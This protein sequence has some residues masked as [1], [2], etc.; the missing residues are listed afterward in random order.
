[1]KIFVGYGYNPRDAWIE[2]LVFQLIKAFGNE[3]THGKQ[4]YGGTLTGG[5]GDELLESNAMIG[6]RTRRGDPDSTGSY[7]THPWVDDELLTVAS[8]KKHIPFIEVRETQVELPAGMLLQKLQGKQHIVYE[9]QRRDQ[10]LV[11][12]ALALGKWQREPQWLEIGLLVQHLS[13]LKE[14]LHHPDLRCVYRVLKPNTPEEKAEARFTKILSLRHGGLVIRTDEVPLNAELQVEVQLEERTLWY[15]AWES[16]NAPV[17][18]LAA[19]PR[20]GEVTSRL[21]GRTMLPPELLR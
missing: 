21:S 13:D 10:C 4:T 2:D 5:V 12:I 9:E 11:E 14:L 1:M 7:R 15:S 3:V 8:F 20:P 19:A 18:H 16:L 6:F 17:V